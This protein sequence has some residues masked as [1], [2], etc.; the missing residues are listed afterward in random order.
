MQR[1][2]EIKASE[3]INRYPVNKAAFFGSIL[4]NDFNAESDVDIIVD[5]ISG[6]DGLDFFGLKE[7]LETEL[8]RSVDLITFKSL[9]KAK[10]SFKNHVESE[11]HIF[12][13]REN[14]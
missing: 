5:F 6:S 8:Q 7:D 9:N 13:D 11:A 10:S 12:Y 4:K 2:I 3:I 1:D 14:T